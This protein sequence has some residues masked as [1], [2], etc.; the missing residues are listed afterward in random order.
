MPYFITDK[1][2]DCSGWATVK[3]DGEVIGCHTT[4]QDAIDQM[5]AV[6][7]AEDMEPGGERQV[8]LNV[9]AYIRSAARKGLDYY[10]QGL[11]GDGLVDRRQGDSCERLGCKTSCGFGCIKE[12]KC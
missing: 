10:G 11:A 9:P 1:S 6:S 2:P 12:L 4:K 3:E 5:V 8:S 7:I